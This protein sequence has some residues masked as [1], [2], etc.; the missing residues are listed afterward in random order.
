MFS[1]TSRF[2]VLTL[3]YSFWTFFTSV[4]Q[5]ANDNHEEQCIITV[6]TIKRVAEIQEPLLNVALQIYT[7]R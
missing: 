3:F 5:P 4:L 1:L 2:Y 6:L 7:V